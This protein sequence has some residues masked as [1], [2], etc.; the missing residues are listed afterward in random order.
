MRR[1][2]FPSLQFMN[3]DRMRPLLPPFRNGRSMP[4]RDALLSSTRFPYFKV[5]L[6]VRRI[7]SRAACFIRG[8]PGW[9][10]KAGWTGTEWCISADQRA[11]NQRATHQPNNL[12]IHCSI[13][14]LTINKENKNLANCVFKLPYQKTIIV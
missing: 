14:L 8:R 6:M 9:L 4:L 2:K 5:P 11:K 12:K 7:G 1:K 10:G 3:R 13:N